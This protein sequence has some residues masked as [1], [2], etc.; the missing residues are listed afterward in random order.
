MSEPGV[1]VPIANMR[2]VGVAVGGA[3]CAHTRF[4]QIKQKANTA[5]RKN[6]FLICAPHVEAKGKSSSSM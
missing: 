2:V 5:K 3:F 6:T 4:G 1:M